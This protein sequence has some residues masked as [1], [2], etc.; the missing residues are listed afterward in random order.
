[1]KGQD[2][3]YVGQVAPALPNN[4][5]LTLNCS[6]EADHPRLARRRLCQDLE[7]YK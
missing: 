2:I 6:D 4:V 3:Y 1:M 7:E 5:L